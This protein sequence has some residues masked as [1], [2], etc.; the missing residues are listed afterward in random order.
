MRRNI[1][2]ITS[3]ALLCAIALYLGFS[4]KEVEALEPRGTWKDV[5]SDYYIIF[6]SDSFVESTYNVRR[7]F[8]YTDGGILLTDAAGYSYF[9]ELSK[10]AGG[11][12]VVHL[13]GELHTMRRATEHEAAN[14][15][16]YRWGSN[17]NGKCIAAYSLKQELPTDYFLRLYEGNVFTSTI[18][19][20]VTSGKYTFDSDGNILLLTEQGT[21]VDSLHRWSNGAAFGELTAGVQ[22]TEEWLS[23]VELLGYQLTGTIQDIMLGTVY[24]FVSDTICM[25]EQASGEQTEFLYFMSPDGLITMTDAAGSGV[26]DYLWFDLTSGKAYRYVLDV[27]DWFAYLHGDLVPDIYN[28]N[29]KQEQAS[30]STVAVIPGLESGDASQTFREPKQSIPE[31]ERVPVGTNT[32][33]VG[34]A[35]LEED[36]SGEDTP[37]EDEALPDGQMPE[38]NVEPDELEIPEGGTE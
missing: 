19:G 23:P 34:D 2:L 25:R 9:V 28:P 15:L 24:D 12:A 37:A 10:N 11:L 31:G 20:N 26:M 27:D 18:D 35:S 6:S 7:P 16:L 1:A 29:G 32:P 8:S 14:P 30:D 36:E 13:N 3:C 5:E 4:L 17:V 33:T 22:L 21:R 38:E